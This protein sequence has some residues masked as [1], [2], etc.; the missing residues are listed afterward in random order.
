[1]CTYVHTLCWQS[2]FHGVRAVT[3]LSPLLTGVQVKQS[4]I[5]LDPDTNMPLLRGDGIHMQKQ[6]T[7][8]GV[9]CTQTRQKHQPSLKGGKQFSADLSSPHPSSLLAQEHDQFL[10]STSTLSEKGPHYVAW[11][12]L[13]P[14]LNG[15]PSL[16]L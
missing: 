4:A 5:S 6:R 9:A 12:S 16:R 11:S 3:P 2:T 8:Q 14:G 10:I 7:I 13:F 15:S 1:M